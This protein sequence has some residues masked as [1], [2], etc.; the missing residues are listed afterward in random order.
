L[1]ADAIALIDEKDTSIGF[2]QVESLVVKAALSGETGHGLSENY[3]GRPVL[4]SYAPLDI[5][6]LNWVIISENDLDEAFAPVSTLVST[7]LFW[8]LIALAVISV[9]T[10][11]TAFKYVSAFIAPLHYVTGSL[12]YIAKDI[13]A[14][15]V[16]LTQ[17]LKPPG[18]NKLANEMSAGINVVLEKFS[19]VL[20]KLGTVTDNISSSSEQVSAMSFDSKKNMST[21]TSETEQIATAIT[22]LA[23]SSGEVANTA[24]QGAEATRIVDQ[25][26]KAGTV[27]V[28]EAVST[29][30]ELA[31]NLS[32]AS[33]VINDLD[34]DSENIGS[35]LAVIQSI[36]EQTNLLALNAAIEAARAGEQGR[37]FAVVA[38][39][40]RT[41]AARTQDATKEIKGIINQLQT[42]SK[43]AVN[44]MNEGC[45]MANLGLE[46]AVSAGQALASIESKVVDID[47]MNTMIAAA[48]QE[49]CNVA[50]EVNKNVVHITSL[51][52]QTQ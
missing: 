14:R 43:E 22:E 24:K 18:N 49:Q 32:S 11:F 26:T 1:S 9:L 39:E 42:R 45:N 41:L 51:S 47:N 40:V 6:G 28:N 50:E 25:D 27:I 12:Q 17:L 34:Q 44:V 46:K 15:N 10:A 37:G 23:A 52:E 36:A 2:Q 13:E 3:L 31:E 48:S 16:D 38:D 33:S 8:S 5:D 21:Q 35:V 4:T 19:A 29:I 30:T 7:I 20:K